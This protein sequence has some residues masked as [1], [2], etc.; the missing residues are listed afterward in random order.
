MIRR[1]QKKL[2][3][4]SPCPFFHVAT[5]GGLL[6]L[7]ARSFA[8]FVNL[9]SPI[10]VGQI[11]YDTLKT[12]KS[13]YLEERKNLEKPPSHLPSCFFFA[14]TLPVRLLATS[15][16]PPGHPLVVLFSCY[17]RQRPVTMVAEDLHLLPLIS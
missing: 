9:H 13:L 17:K 16:S 5:K 4:W 1:N 15:P 3:K 10:I 8:F 2:K 14:S 11:F 7:T 12:Y 6:P